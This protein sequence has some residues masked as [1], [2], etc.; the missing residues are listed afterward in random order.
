VCLRSLVW[1]G[2]EPG[3]QFIQVSR[4]HGLLGNDD[5]RLA[6][7]ER[8]R[9]EILHHI[10]RQRVDCPVHDVR[11]RDGGD[12][13]ITVGRRA[14]DPAYADGA[15]GAR[16]VFN[17]QRLGERLT[18][19]RGKNACHPVRG[20]ARRKGYD[21]R[22]WSR[23]INLCVCRYYPEGSRCQSAHNCWPCPHGFPP[24]SRRSPCL[25]ARSAPSCE[26]S[27]IRPQESESG[28]AGSHETALKKFLSVCELAL[29][30]EMAA[31]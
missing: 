17:R 2:L 21:H 11:T 14:G 1:I 20:S 9:F 5:E 23:W 24:S 15:A 16:H 3:D 6:R 8:D 29:D 4:W 12:E 27:V 25:G 28:P 18:H 10:V 31:T 22:D 19:V 30:R 26:A 7:D 13:R